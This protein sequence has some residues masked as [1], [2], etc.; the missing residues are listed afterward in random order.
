M[1][2]SLSANK[3]KKSNA[4]HKKKVKKCLWLRIEAQNKQEK[5]TKKKESN[6]NFKSVVLS[7]RTKTT[8]LKKHVYRIKCDNWYENKRIYN[9]ITKVKLSHPNKKH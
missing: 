5:N 7:K 1:C 9:Y 2:T 6:L 8:Q 3:Q 4:K